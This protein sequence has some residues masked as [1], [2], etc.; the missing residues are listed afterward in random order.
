MKTRLLLLTAFLAIST[1]AM[2]S[3]Y[4]KYIKQAQNGDPIA[5]CIIGFCY[6]LGD[7]VKKD[8]AQATH[9]KMGCNVYGYGSG[10]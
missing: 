10:S 9:F 8:N 2:A 3:D 4:T 1:I 7:G 6:T 5:Q